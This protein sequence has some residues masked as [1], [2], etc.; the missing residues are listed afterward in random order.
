MAIP[1]DFDDEPPTT[2]DAPIPRALLEATTDPLRVDDARWT[3][4]REI[5]RA[6]GRREG[7]DAAFA[8]LAEALLVVG[9]SP[10]EIP[11]ILAKVRARAELG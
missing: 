2:L 6:E 8:A 11:A 1:T 10:G 4:G 3:A 7:F 5:G 9:V